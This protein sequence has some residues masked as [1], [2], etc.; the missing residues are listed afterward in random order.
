MSSVGGRGGRGG[1]RPG[2]ATSSGGRTVTRRT[3]RT[4][5]GSGPATDTPWG[6]SLKPVPKRVVSEV[7]EETLKSK[8]VDPKVTL[9]K[10]KKTTG[11]KTIK[12]VQIKDPPSKAESLE[13]QVCPRIMILHGFHFCF[14]QAVSSKPLD[15]QVCIVQR[16][17]CVNFWLF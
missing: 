11:V 15:P 5:A 7:T 10:S 8:K 9:P 2:V 1:L 4:V 6:V 12:S 14:V 16:W 13:L 17:I 3:V